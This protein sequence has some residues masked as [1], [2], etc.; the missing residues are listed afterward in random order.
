[1]RLPNLCQLW[2][3]QEFWLV[4]TGP[5]SVR[6]SQWGVGRQHDVALLAEG[7]QLALVEVGVALNLVDGGLDLEGKKNADYSFNS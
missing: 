7:Q 2:I 6:G 5:G 1:M 3:V 4:W